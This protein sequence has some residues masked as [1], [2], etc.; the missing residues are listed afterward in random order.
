MFYSGRRYIYDIIFENTTRLTRQLNELQFSP[1]LDDG[2]S[3]EVV[4]T[5]S[6]SNET[7]VAHGSLKAT[8]SPSRLHNLQ[9]DSEQKQSNYYRPSA[10]ESDGDL[11]DDPDMGSLS[12]P[13]QDGVSVNDTSPRTVSDAD[14]LDTPGHSDKCLT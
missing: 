5:D 13:T 12:H 2:G 10:E 4:N 1:A 3:V 8:I 14:I 9:D 7:R 6:D 11:F